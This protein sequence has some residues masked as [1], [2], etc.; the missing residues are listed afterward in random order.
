MMKRRI[1]PAALAMALTGCIS[2]GAEPPDSMLTLTSTA[3]RDA[4]AGRTV[5]SAEAI[6]VM[7]PIVPQE[8]R[9]QRVPVR[10]GATQ[11]AYLKDAM[12]VEMPS[13]LFGRLLGE[14]IA[15]RTGRVVLD[16]AQFSLDPGVELSGQLQSFGI[17]ANSS[18]AVVVYDAALARGGGAVETRRFEARVPVGAIEAGSAGAALNQ[19]AN[20]IAVEVADWV[21][22]GAQAAGG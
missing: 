16:P 19:A 9:T 8:I 20:Q 21:G 6:T 1:L 7:P 10:T 2:F 11:V 4:G 15:A 17:E 22:G 18:E 13:A 14:T 12:W 3:T 5:T